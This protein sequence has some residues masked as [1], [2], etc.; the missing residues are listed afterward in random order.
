MC[1]EV[2]QERVIDFTQPINQGVTADRR[3]LRVRE[4][5]YGNPRAPARGMSI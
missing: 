1:L 2:E 3:G 4:I 5:T